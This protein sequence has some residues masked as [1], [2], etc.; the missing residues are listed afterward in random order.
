MCLRLFEI[1]AFLQPQA[2]FLLLLD[3]SSYFRI[4]S[5]LS[6]NQYFIFPRV[7]CFCSHLIQN[8]FLPKKNSLL[9]KGCF[10]ER[11]RLIP[12]LRPDSSTFFSSF[13]LR[14]KDGRDWRV[15]GHD[16]P[17]RSRVRLCCPRRHLSKIIHFIILT[18]FCYF[19]NKL[20]L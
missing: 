18:V 3:E 8:V 7:Q 19:F 16:V 5:S 9:K 14:T 11:F 17:L 13:S 20:F 10:L 6:G 2:K 12:E 1:G 4:I 15:S